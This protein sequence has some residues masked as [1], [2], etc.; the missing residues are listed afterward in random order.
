MYLFIIKPTIDFLISLFAV[1][2]LSPL[3]IITSVFVFCFIG[4][5]VLFCQERAGH[6]ER[7]FLLYKFS[8]MSDKHDSNGELLPD[9]ERMTRFGSFLRKTS[10]DELPQLFNVLKGDIS[11]VGPRPLLVE[12][13]PFYNKEQR[14]RHQVKPGITGW[15]QING[16]NSIT[17][18]EKFILDLYYVENVTLM[19]DFKILFNTVLKV[20]KTSGIYN[21]SGTT[22]DKFT[23]SQQ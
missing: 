8:T 18:E 7:I 20:F 19:L 5:K 4:K 6:H 22:M 15:A 17:W 13:L 23:G 3:I 2:F 12:Y 16:R 10:L 1:I 11:L 21:N 14:K 9:N